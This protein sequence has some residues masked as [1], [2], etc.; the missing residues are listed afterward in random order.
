M[1]GEA[2]GTHDEVADEGEAK[3]AIMLVL[4]TVV[5]AMEC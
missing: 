5:E 4:P 3:D 1:E 2:A